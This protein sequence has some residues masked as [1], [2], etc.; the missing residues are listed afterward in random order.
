M[1]QYEVPPDP[2]LV[3]YRQAEVAFYGAVAM[4]NDFYR[5]RNGPHF[6]RL[7]RLA[8]LACYYAGFHRNRDAWPEP[9]LAAAAREMRSLRIPDEKITAVDYRPTWRPAEL[10][11]MPAD[12]EIS[13]RNR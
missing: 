2:A 5:E 8:G 11:T 4:R 12:I 6:Q 10:G 3:I 7:H 13:S 9:T 1:P